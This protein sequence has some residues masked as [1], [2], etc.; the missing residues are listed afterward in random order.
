MDDN[1]AMRKTILNWRW[2][3]ALPALLLLL[4]FVL[5]GEMFAQLDRAEAMRRGQLMIELIIGP[6][7]SPL[8]K[9]VHGNKQPNKAK[10]G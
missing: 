1:N 6:L 8:A 10:G 4:P 9:W 7:V 3:A 2:W 5:L